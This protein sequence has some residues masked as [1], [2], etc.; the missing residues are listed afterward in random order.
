VKTQ[1]P[2]V[3]YK[4]ERLLAT[5]LATQLLYR[6]RCRQETLLGAAL[7]PLL[8]LVE[9]PLVV[10]QDFVPTHMQAELQ[11]HQ[12]GEL[13]R[14]QLLAV[15]PEHA[16]RLLDQALEGVALHVVH[17]GAEQQTGAGAQ[18]AVALVDQIGQDELL[19][20]HVRLRNGHQIDARVQFVD[21]A[22]LPLYAVGE[23]KTD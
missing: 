8:G 12:H 11:R 2:K 21:P 13:G 7:G 14:D 4:Y 20:V 16:L 23:E 6:L 15:Q 17:L 10:R 9:Q 5:A 18:L 3:C 1:H 22:H 19:K